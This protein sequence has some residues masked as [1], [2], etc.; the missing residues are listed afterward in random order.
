MTSH[1]DYD[2]SVGVLPTLEKHPF[3][4]QVAKDSVRLRQSGTAPNA[5]DSK[6]RTPDDSPLPHIFSKIMSVLPGE[7]YDD[8]P[9]EVSAILAKLNV[10]E[11][12]EIKKKFRSLPRFLRLHGA[13]IEVSRDNTTVRRWE[14]PENS[15][16]EEDILF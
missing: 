1:P 12:D 5:L 11:R 2:T 8:T 16:A 6:G 3:I 9:V 10:E 14:E 7:S 13:A 4:F 15:S